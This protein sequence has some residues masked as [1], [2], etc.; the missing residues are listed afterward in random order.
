MSG[1]NARVLVVDDEAAVRNN[2]VAFLED[3]GFEV[4]E[5]ES[6]EAAL[7]LLEQEDF[8][9]GIID[10]R[11]P[12]MDGDALI[13]ATSSR[14]PSMKFLVHTGSSTYA[15]PPAL[16]DIGMTPEDVF[17]KPINDMGLLADAIRRL[18]P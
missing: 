15:L 3:E 1:E 8:A 4:R 7:Q 14:K 13:I 16:I 18:L 9:V 6:G 5:A 11:L 17:R 10:L 2:L 12:G